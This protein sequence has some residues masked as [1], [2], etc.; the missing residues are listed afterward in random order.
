MF[1]TRRIG[2]PLKWLFLRK[3]FWAVKA[4]PIK[5][6]MFYV[7][8]LVPNGA[9]N[10]FFILTQVE[11]NAEIEGEFE[12]ARVVALSKGQEPAKP[13]T[14]PGHCHINPLRNEFAQ[15]TDVGD[16]TNAEKVSFQTG[17]P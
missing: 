5:L 7:F 14:F 1:C 10:R 12:R 3:N 9:T 8:A 15:V 16:L 17:S 13:D 6:N 11:V 4:K 2:T